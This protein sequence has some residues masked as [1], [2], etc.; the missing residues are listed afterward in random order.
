MM[1]AG[2]VICENRKARFHYEILEKFE[3]GIALLGSEVKSL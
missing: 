1:A 3:A 2:K